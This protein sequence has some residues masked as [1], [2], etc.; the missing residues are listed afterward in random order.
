MV[1]TSTL[2][3]LSE[4]RK[5]ISRCSIEDL[6]NLAIFS[7]FSQENDSVSI[8]ELVELSSVD[9]IV[10]HNNLFSRPRLFRKKKRINKKSIYFLR[11]FCYC[12]F[13]GRIGVSETL[14]LNCLDELLRIHG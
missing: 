2:V 3:F 8:Q 6:F 10:G 9:F 5:E 14:G 4:E 7:V 12:Y 1:N 13:A 11:I